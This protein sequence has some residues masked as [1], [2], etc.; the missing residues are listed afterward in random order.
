M[1]VHSISYLNLMIQKNAVIWLDSIILPLYEECAH[2]TIDTADQE[3]E[4]IAK[5]IIERM[6]LS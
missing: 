5:I 3:I 4:S 1:I 6:K 2:L